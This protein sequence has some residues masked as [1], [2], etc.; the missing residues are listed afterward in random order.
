MAYTSSIESEQAQYELD[1][2]SSRVFEEALEKDLNVFFNAI[3]SDFVLNYSE[4]GTI[5]DLLIYR[6]SLEGILSKAYRR[7][8]KFFAATFM[9]NLEEHIDQGKENNEDVS[10]E[11]ELLKVR[12]DKNNLIWLA[13]IR[14]IQMKVVVDAESILK[15]TN[16]VIN[17]EIDKAILSLASDGDLT[18]SQRDINRKVAKASKAG[19]SQRNKT[20][21]RLISESEVLSAGNK[22]SDI[23]ASEIQT[24]I[25]EKQKQA[26]LAA[27]GGA[28]DDAEQIEA[29][30]NTKLKKK[31][32]TRRDDRVRKAHRRVHGQTR[33]INEPFLVMG[34]LLMQPKDRS[35][36][37]SNPNVMG[38]RCRSYSYWT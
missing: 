20:R 25:S 35:L 32:I 9:R 23:E 15:T 31:W 28:V 4:T 6:S 12:E 17:K 10:R 7:A 38:C 11:E 21:S 27:I 14:Y 19:I 13:A 16:K 33:D 37:A 3:L 22:A 30:G 29:L 2:Q 5:Q 26:S 1:D 36:G 18:G 34:E 8:M 24:G